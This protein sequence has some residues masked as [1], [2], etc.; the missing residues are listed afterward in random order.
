[1]GA[2]SRVRGG[3]SVSRDRG[4]RGGSNGFVRFAIGCFVRSVEGRQ[5]A[6]AIPG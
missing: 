4:N 5:V 2:N 6:T 1:M 3:L